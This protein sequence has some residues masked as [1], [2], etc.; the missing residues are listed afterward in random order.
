MVQMAELSNTTGT[1]AVKG[2]SMPVKWM[3]NLRFLTGID[4]VQIFESSGGTNIVNEISLPSREGNNTTQRSRS[5]DVFPSTPPPLSNNRN[6]EL[7]IED[8]AI[9]RVHAIG[10]K[11]SIRL[12]H[13]MMGHGHFLASVLKKFELVS[14]KHWKSSN[15][16]NRRSQA[17]LPPRS[18]TSRRVQY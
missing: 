8:L 18:N 7:A 11:H 17:I 10:Y 3:T 4:V 13:L 15:F 5:F 6:G 14:R 9:F 12:L 2:S 1:A 16:P